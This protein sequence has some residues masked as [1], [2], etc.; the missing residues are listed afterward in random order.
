MQKQLSLCDIKPGEKATVCYLKTK[1]SMRRR[2]LDIGLVKD[3]CVECIGKSPFGDPSAF[4]IRGAVIAIRSDDSKNI[5]V[6]PL[7]SEGD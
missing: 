7:F 6:T 5:M 2:F 1:G 4:L 3:T